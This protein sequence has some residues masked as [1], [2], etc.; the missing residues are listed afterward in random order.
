MQK[1]L[2]V[3]KPLQLRIGLLNKQMLGWKLLKKTIVSQQHIVVLVK[4]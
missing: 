1:L 2:V 4:T 3:Y